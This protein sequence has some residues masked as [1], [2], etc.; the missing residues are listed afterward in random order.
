LAG[1][2]WSKRRL[3]CDGS[4]QKTIGIRLPGE[5]E[6]NGREKEDQAKKGSKKAAKEKEKPAGK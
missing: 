2:I 5:E 1:I 4:A 3:G 6:G